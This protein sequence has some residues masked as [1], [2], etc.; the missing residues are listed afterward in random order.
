MGLVLAWYWAGRNCDALYLGH[1]TSSFHGRKITQLLV[2]AVVD[3]HIVVFCG[4]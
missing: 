1:K 3:Q 2:T 4:M